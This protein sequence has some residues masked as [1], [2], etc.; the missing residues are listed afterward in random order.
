[1]P[2]TCRRILSQ[3]GVLSKD[4][5]EMSDVIALYYLIRTDQIVESVRSELIV[6]YC[7]FNDAVTSNSTMISELK[8]MLLELAVA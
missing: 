3:A 6:S 2:C 1:M 4:P 8:R 7:L 5:Y